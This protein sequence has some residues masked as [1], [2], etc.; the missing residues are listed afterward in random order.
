MLLSH[1]AVYFLYSKRNYAFAR[2]LNRSML[3]ISESRVRRLDEVQIQ[4]NAAG[5]AFF[6]RGHLGCGLS[7]TAAVSA[8][9]V[10]APV[11]PAR[12]RRLEERIRRMRRAVQYAYRRQSD[13]QCYY[14]LHP[15]PPFLKIVDL[16]KI[17]STNF[18]FG[19]I[20]RFFTRG[21]AK[22]FFMRGGR[23]AFAPL[24]L[25]LK[26]FADFALCAANS[27]KFKFGISGCAVVGNIRKSFFAVAFPIRSDFVS[28]RRASPAEVFLRF[29]ILP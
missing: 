11:V 23:N 22:N 1:A 15:V 2:K 5:A 13:C 17:L 18:I 25:W 16:P 27:L 8:M 20:S 6:V 3:K 21:V 12:R 4:K 24:S 14:C 7:P 29:E 28:R 26:I 19:R 10:S 9:V